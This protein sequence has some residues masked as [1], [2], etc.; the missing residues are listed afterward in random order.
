MALFVL[1]YAEQDFRLT[2][3]FSSEEEAAEWGDAWN[4]RN[5]DDPRWNTIEL[6]SDATQS[7]IYALPIEKP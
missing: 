6:D 1:T 4:Q 5:S 2:G 7:A 3:P